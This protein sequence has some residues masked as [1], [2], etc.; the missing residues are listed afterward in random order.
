MY[1]FTYAATYN[2]ISSIYAVLRVCVQKEASQSKNLSLSI[3]FYDLSNMYQHISICILFLNKRRVYE[4]IFKELFYLV[5]MLFIIRLNVLYFYVLDK[6]L[7]IPS[8]LALNIYVIFGVVN[9]GICVV[10]YLFSLC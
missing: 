8:V 9:L 2:Q 3:F 10:E 5:V 7:P 1:N 4:K 6:S